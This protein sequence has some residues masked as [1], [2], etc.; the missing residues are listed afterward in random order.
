[1][2]N[3]ERHEEHKLKLRPCIRHGLDLKIIYLQW[4]DL[5]AGFT[6]Q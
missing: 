4:S 1:M 2:W 5:T 3:H 6:F